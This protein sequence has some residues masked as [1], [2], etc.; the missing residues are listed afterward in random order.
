MAN[1]GVEPISQCCGAKFEFIGSGAL[2]PELDPGYWRCS[3]CG[4]Q[5]EV[6]QPFARVGRFTGD[7]YYLYKAET[8]PDSANEPVVIDRDGT[9]TKPH[10]A[11]SYGI[12]DQLLDIADDTSGARELSIRHAL[13]EWGHEK[14]GLL[15]K[16]TGNKTTAEEANYI[17]GYNTGVK[18]AYQALITE[19][20]DNGD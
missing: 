8:T 7:D 3:K 5:S 1:R 18:H 10:Q 9:R 14:I 12:I 20:E 6:K 16:S 11:A 2:N 4:F 17:T 19:L 15:M 13:S